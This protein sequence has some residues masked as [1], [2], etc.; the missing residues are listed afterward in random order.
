MGAGVGPPT[1]F[2]QLPQKLSP[3][4]TSAE[5][6]G[7]VAAKP[8]PQARQNLLSSGFSLPQLLQKISCPSNAVRA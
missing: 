4:V 7:Q 3:G 6:F 5:H 1:W 2:P 8:W